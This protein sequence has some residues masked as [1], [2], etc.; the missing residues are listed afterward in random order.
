[1]CHAIFATDDLGFSPEFFSRA[2]GEVYLAGLNSTIIP[3]P[4]TPTDAK[5]DPEAVRKMKDCAAAMMGNVDGGELES[6]RESLVCYNKLRHS[7]EA[8]CLHSAS[9]LL[10]PAVDQ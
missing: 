4:E 3:L 9:A 2:R 6:L 10:H 7:P 8:K 5:P 1:M